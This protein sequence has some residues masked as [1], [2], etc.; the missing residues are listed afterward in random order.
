[1][2]KQTL[3]L[4]IPIVALSI[5]VVAIIFGSLVKMTKLKADA[6]RL[7]LPNPET[8]ARLA[9]LEHE[10]ASL[11]QELLDAQERLDF[12][13]RL[14]AQRSVGDAKEGR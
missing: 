11:R 8:D 6:Q 1:M 3:A 7:A 4:M 13:E 2:D 5:P 14:L 12:T 10:V 9:A